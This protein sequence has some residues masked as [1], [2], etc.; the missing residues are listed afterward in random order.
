MLQSMTGF[1]QADI[2]GLFGTLRVE[3]RTLNSKQLDVSSLR[4]PMR[5]REMELPVRTALQEHVKRGKIDVLVTITRSGAC[6]T[7]RMR[8]N[9]SLFAEGLL[10]LQKVCEETCRDCSDDVAVA[11]V[12]R[13][14][15]I[16]ITEEQPLS[17]EER[18]AFQDVL[19]KAIEK[20][21]AFREEE[22]KA[23]WQ[24][25]ETQ[26]RFIQECMGQVDG[27][28]E[29]RRSHLIE[30]FNDTVK[31]VNGPLNVPLDPDRLAQEL[32]YKLERLDIN[33][34][35]DR[36]AQHLEYFRSTAGQGCGQGRK[37]LF[38]S[39]EMGRE[40]NTI[41]SKAHSV[42]IQRLVVEMKEALERIKEQLLNV[43]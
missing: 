35:L 7:E 25:M 17:T 14:P 12:L 6:T 3:I 5:Y 33:E 19:R 26:L 37:L 24:S 40:I 9:G 11:S 41:G 2:S 38:I 42:R 4:L 36:L 18:Q 28:R 8:I 15:D 39:Q 22:G 29:E 43:L 30:T 27:L 10:A 34:E 23:L 31:E 32:F 21:I 16:W 20:L 1:G 13:I